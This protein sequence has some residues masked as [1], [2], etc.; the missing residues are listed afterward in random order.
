MYFDRHRLNLTK[1]KGDISIEPESNSDGIINMNASSKI[2]K[3]TVINQMNTDVVLQC[4]ILG[5]LGPFEV[6]QSLF[7]EIISESTPAE[8]RGMRQIVFDV[9]LT[10]SPN[11]GIYSL[12]VAFR[13]SRDDDE[14]FHI[15]KYI[16][17]VI[18][19]DVV[20][21]L[22][23]TRPYRR[24]RRVALPFDHNVLIERGEPPCT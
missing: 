9:K 24:R 10:K 15:V 16:K 19:D 18:V 5:S 6:H 23:P 4:A 14:P 3:L 12:P 21:R 11:P 20:M 22:Q 17:A 7:P 8:I 13:F 1:D 2:L